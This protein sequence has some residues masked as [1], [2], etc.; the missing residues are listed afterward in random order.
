MFTGQ[1]SSCLKQAVSVAFYRP[2]CHILIHLRSHT[3]RQAHA[4]KHTSCVY[5]CRYTLTLTVC[6]HSHSHAHSHSRLATLRTWITTTHAR[7]HAHWCIL[8][9]RAAPWRDDPRAA[10]YL[11]ELAGYSLDELGTW[12]TATEKAPMSCIPPPPVSACRLLLKFL[13]LPCGP[14]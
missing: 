14:V 13:S 5:T 9:P 10:E 3:C 2:A 7:V 4:H 12:L 8:I 1:C 11:Q 6:A